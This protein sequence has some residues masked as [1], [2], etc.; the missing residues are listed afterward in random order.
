MEMEIVEKIF[1]S[2]YS[3]INGYNISSKARK[4]IMSSDK[5]LTYGEVVPQEFFKILSEVN[6]KPGEVFYDLGS[7]LGK[8][9]FLASLFF[10]FSKIVGIELLDDLCQASQSVLTRFEKEIK[11]NL[12]EKN[13]VIS[14]ENANFLDV[15]F[16]DA[17]IVFTHSTCFN[18]ETL[19]S[20]S[21]RA[22][23]LKPGAW[24]ISITK[25]LHS[26]FLALFKSG[27]Y[28]MNWGK[29]TGYFYQKV[30]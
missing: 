4:K 21:R 28:Y 20:L 23:R 2:L 17:D 11:P 13:Q 5:A 8:A 9:V 1:N 29:A 15:D 7:G 6:P 25:T 27:E 22:E 3:D 24:V 16:S 26:P 10:D 19:D 18:E 14:F 12:R 30:I